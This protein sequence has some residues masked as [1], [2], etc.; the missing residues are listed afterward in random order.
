MTTLAR[1]ERIVEALIDGDVQLALTI[2]ED[3]AID[4]RRAVAA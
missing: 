2:A 3:L 1:L 4:L